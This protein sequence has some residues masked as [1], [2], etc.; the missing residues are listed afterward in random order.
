MINTIVLF[1][2]V[3]AALEVGLNLESVKK[4]LKSKIRLT[5]RPFLSA[6]GLVEAVLGLDS[7][8]DSYSDTEADENVED[9][10]ISTT[11]VPTTDHRPEMNTSSGLN[12]S[13][14]RGGGVAGRSTE[15]T[16][17]LSKNISGEEGNETTYLTDAGTSNSNSNTTQ[18]DMSRDDRFH[19]KGGN[20]E[21]ESKE[22][23]AMACVKDKG[24]FSHWSVLITFYVQS[25]NK[26]TLHVDFFFF[27]GVEFEKEMLKLRDQ[28][29]CK[30]CMD[31][32]V[33]IVFL[34]CGHL[35]SCIRCA[36]VLSICVL[37]RQHIKA[38][39]RTYL[40]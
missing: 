36:T 31:D 23:H 14:S 2:S 19:A 24:K 5:G 22:P 20:C 11:L 13:G 34:P 8:Y 6:E 40:S 21:E 7:D 9:G 29:L 10:N 37:C 3:Q 16:A 39:V 18:S 26:V 12:G 38:V 28:T 4:A 33:G 35:V 1:S 15:T 32:Q 17:R 27:S 30:V 25:E